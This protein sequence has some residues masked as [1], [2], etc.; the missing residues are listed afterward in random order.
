LESFVQSLV[1]F[2][3]LLG[4]LIFIHEF[5]HFAVAKLA[6][7]KVLKFSLGFPPALIKRKWG[8]T[9]YTLSWIPLGGYVKLLGEDKEAE[10]EIPPEEVHRAYSNKP[11][12][13]RFAVIAAGPVSNYL[14]ALVLLCVGYMVGWPVLASEIGK[15]L[16]DTPARVAGLKE[17]DLVTAIDGLPV[18]RWDDMRSTIEKH[19][20]RTLT[21]TVERAGRELDLKVTPVLGDQKDVF[22]RPTGRIGVVPSGKRLHLDGPRSAW[23]GVRFTFQLTGLVV[24]TLVKLVKFE[25]SPKALSGPI[26]I[27]QASGES[28]KAG[29][30]SFIFLLSFISI[31]LAVINLLPVPI[32][33]GGHLMFLLVEAV[34]RRPLTGKVREV[35]TQAGLLFIIL[36][37]GLVFYN[38]ITR[39][40]EQGWALKP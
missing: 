16:D 29:V 4:V 37:M 36:L 27:A 38:D 12:W 30:F 40:I 23:E 13:V 11:I 5:G 14:L 39:I 28:L 24:E 18:Q 2:V 15:V 35:A 22:G 20:N 10:D 8:E 9:E 33:D 19:P 17:G 26:T 7:I 32:L 1:G 6:G 25:I 34:T 21:F 31:N 3:A